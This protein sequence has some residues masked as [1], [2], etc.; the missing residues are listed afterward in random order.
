VASRLLCGTLSGCI[1]HAVYR[2]GEI[3]VE[4]GHLVLLDSILH[5][6]EGSLFG[7]FR[8]CGIGE[9][10][11]VLRQLEIRVL[12]EEWFTHVC[13]RRGFVRSGG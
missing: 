2:M 7:G 4:R 5:R 11:D 8:A 10:E 12:G 6:L 1:Q 3:P 9:L 13:E